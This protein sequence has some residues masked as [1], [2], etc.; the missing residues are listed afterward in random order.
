VVLITNVAECLLNLLLVLIKHL[1]LTIKISND[2]SESASDLSHDLILLVDSQLLLNDFISFA[3]LVIRLHQSVTVNP[4][5]LRATDVQ[6]LVFERVLAESQLVRL[7][8][9]L[10]V[11]DFFKVS[12]ALKDVLGLV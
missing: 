3:L 10:A 8:H 6:H 1:E 4:R 9:Y 11:Q 5:L 7:V 2:L 12:N